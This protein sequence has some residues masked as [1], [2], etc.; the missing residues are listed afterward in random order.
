MRQVI[1]GAL[2]AVPLLWACGDGV[3]P[4]DTITV[5]GSVVD[6]R[7]RPLAGAKVLV[8]GL[9]P[10]VAD[11]DGHFSISGVK[12]PYRIAAAVTSTPAAAIYDELTGDSVALVVPVGSLSASLPRQATVSGTVTGGA[13]YPEPSDH[14]SILLFESP[15]TSWSWHPSRT[16]GA[17][18]MP[19]TWAGPGATTGTLHALQWQFDSETRLPTGYA[20]YGTRTGVTVTD[21]GTLSGQDIQM[22]PVSTGSLSGTVTLP[23]GYALTA[24][25]LSAVFV[26]SLAPV[27]RLFSD[28]TNATSF[29]YV[30]PDLA[31]A[32]FSVEVDARA[33]DAFVT[34]TKGGVSFNATGIP[35]VLPA[36]PVLGGLEDGATGV[37]A[38]TR[39]SWSRMSGA[40][41]LLKIMPGAGQGVQY[42]VFTGDTTATIP[43][44][45]SLGLRLTPGTA[46]EWGVTGVAPFANLDALALA[47]AGNT[48]PGD[49]SSGYSAT[50]H[51]TAAR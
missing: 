26:T 6:I 41:Y 4:G 30:T 3:G 45:A 8:T 22:S 17:Y 40:I 19:L 13:G 21:G 51:F 10:V 23:A 16:T 39:V 49:W 31:G 25:M 38:G 47:L 36:A 28:I 27:W 9:T 29:A 34:A 24:K 35:V 48:L 12:T 33:G 20:G 15:E 7:L 5:S 44:L 1:S 46:Y 18:Q 2:I 50:R 11:P 42:Y 14:T 43:D 37:G 32:S